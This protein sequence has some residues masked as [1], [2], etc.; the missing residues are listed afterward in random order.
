MSTGGLE[1]D[2]RMT[3]GG[4]E[5]GSRWTGGDNYPGKCAFQLRKPLLLV[6]KSRI[7]TRECWFSYI[8]RIDCGK[9]LVEEEQIKPMEN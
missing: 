2:W 7:F 6:R 3:G 1:E 5:E 8:C 9:A 4:L